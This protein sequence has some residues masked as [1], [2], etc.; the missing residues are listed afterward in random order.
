M[1][2]WLAEASGLLPRIQA[3]LQARQAHP[4]RTLVLLPYAQLLPLASRL[5][6]RLY[7]DGFSPRFE[8]TQNWVT[9]L[10][11]RTLDAQDISMDPAV[12]ILTAQALL[13]GSGAQGQESLAPLLVQAAYQLA[14][15]AAAAGPTQRAAWA[16]SARQHA[17]LG[18]DSQA[19]A[20]EARV[21][22]LAVEWAAVSSYTSDALFDP[23]WH[24][25][26]DCLV[27]VQ[28]ANQ[29]SLPAGLAP[30]WVDKLVCLPLAES[31]V[32]APPALSAALALHACEDAED[33]A[34]RT[35]ACLL[36]HIA[37]DRYPV[38]LVSADRALTRRVRAVLDTAGVAVR[39]ENGWKLSTSHAGASVMALL[40]AAQWNASCDAVLTAL[41]QAPGYLEALDA[42]ETAVR[43]DQVRD[44]RHAAD[45]PAV[46][47]SPA[48]LAAC[49]EIEQLRSALA[50]R[51]PLAGWLAALQQVLQKMGL[52]AQL[53]TDG[54]GS[55]LLATLR[56][57][58]ADAAQW[59]QLLDQALWAGQRL[60]LMEFTRWVNQALEGAS[61]Q[62]DYPD[63]EQVVILPLSQ[64]LGRPFGAVVMAGCDEVRLNPSP[65][66]AGVWT[67]AQRAALGLPAREALE[68]QLRQVWR[69][70]LASPACDVLWRTSDDT[71]EA[72]QPS[73]L[74]QQLRLELGGE[75]SAA[76]PRGIRSVTPQPCLP[77]QPTG[78]ALAVDTLSASAYEDLRHCPYRFFAQRMLD[79]RAVDELDAE[80]GKRD[81]GLWLHAVLEQFHAQLAA[82]PVADAASHQALLDATA[83]QVTADM[84][85]PEGE[86]LPFAA[87]WPAVRDGYLGWLADHEAT[88]AV[89]ASGETPQRQALGQ[90]TLVGRIDRTDRFA[91]GSVML[92]DYKTEPSGTTRDRTR[93]PMEDTQI[94]FY[95]ALLPQDTLRAAY[96][97]V[98][99]RDGSTTFEQTE[100]V[101]ARDA[102][103]EGLQHDLQRITAGAPLPAL[104]EGTVC[105]FC[106]VRG[107]CRK[108]FW[109]AA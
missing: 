104:G 82:Q 56:L 52:W 27:L 76:D 42:L 61:F 71:G 67:P 9:A 96:V 55:K 18:M 2:L 102:L 25:T 78:P 50:G 43:R 5:W 47:T 45:S 97:N 48:L 51:K 94:A 80:V 88:G 77:P 105:D 57:T 89:F 10:G 95:A 53:Q 98:G 107:L 24:G 74:V 35:A 84:A 40:R 68:V 22:R 32:A 59:S 7:P 31:G 86:F 12:D 14:P 100:V 85:L 103:I 99:E 34:Q 101:A 20:W 13:A 72:L 15:L 6:A 37:A 65:E 46:R 21:A 28:G 16:Q 11:G 79:L 58:P 30:V 83:Q 81:F 70:A 73:A 93:D 108:D 3:Q 26:L 49:A 75:Q 1:A 8:T 36:Q 54:A 33:E 39:D 109:E 106:Q 69:H 17:G 4:A 90:V 66:P 29:D 38:A 91:D 64:M 19:L 60:D 87:A 23:L 41:K 92:L 44:W 63:Q 62:P